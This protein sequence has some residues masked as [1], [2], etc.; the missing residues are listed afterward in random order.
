MVYF[1]QIIK[2]LILKDCS[3]NSNF[4]FLVLLRTSLL[5]NA[6]WLNKQCSDIEALEYFIICELKILLEKIIAITQLY[7][8]ETNKS[9]VLI[10]LY[11]LHEV[12]HMKREYIWRN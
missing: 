7:C 1:I 6:A 8:G 9:V 12:W 10:C 5:N 11:C 4:K 2:H 3:Y